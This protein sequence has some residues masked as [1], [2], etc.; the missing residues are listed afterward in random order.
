MESIAKA[1]L[2]IHITAGFTS[3]IIFWLPIFLKKG[4]NLHVKI[5][6][7]Y[8]LLMWVVVITAALMSIKNIIIGAYTMAAFLGFLAVITAN[9]LWYGIAVLRHKKGLG[10]SYR[11]KHMMFNATIFI[12][13]ILLVIYGIYLGGEGAGVLM[14]IFG[15]LGITT[16]REVVLMYRNSGE[17][18]NWMAEHIRGMMTSGIAAYTAFAVFG[19]GN[20]FREYLTGYWSV[21]PWV[22]PTIVGLVIIK[23][24]KKSYMKKQKLA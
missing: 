12:T 5:G 8:V 10:E 24:Y 14:L 2:G 3:I 16:G 4:S 9:P 18:S 17:E 23:Y 22:M 7:L 21:V 11:K 20:F 13:G 6:K 1:L 15:I 19:G